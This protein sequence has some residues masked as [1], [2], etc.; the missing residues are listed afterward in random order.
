MLNAGD[1]SLTFFSTADISGL[2][3]TDAGAD[4]DAL[5]FDGLVADIDPSLFVNFETV[6]VTNGAFIT[7]AP[8]GASLLSGPDGIFVLNGS[9]LQLG[10]LDDLLGSLTIDAT[11]TVIAIGD[12]PGL[13]TI[14]GDLTLAGLLDLT[15]G[16]PDDQT[17]V[18][19]D[20]IGQ[21]G[22]IALDVLFGPGGVSE[23][24]LVTFGDTGSGDVQVF[25]DVD[26]SGPVTIAPVPVLIFPSSPGVDLTLAS[27]GVAFDGLFYGLVDF[28]G[29]IFL[30]PDGTY[31]EEV[32]GA[33]AVSAALAPLDRDLFGDLGARIGTGDALRRPGMADG[34][35]GLWA[36]G[37]GSYHNGEVGGGGSNVDFDATHFF[38]Q[39]GVDAFRVDVGDGA[40]VGSVMAHFGRANGDVQ[41]SGAGPDTDFDVTSYGVGVGAT[42]YVGDGDTYFDVAGMVNWHD[43]D[44]AGQD[45]DSMSYVI[46]F[47]A[48]TRIPASDTLSIAPMAQVVYS[49]ADEIDGVTMSGPVLGSG[50]VRVDDLESLEAR[51]LVMLELG[52]GEA[53]SVQFGGGIAYEFMGES[54]TSFGSTEVDTD[55]GGVS[56]EVA[57]R[58]QFRVSETV[59]AFGDLRGR[60]AFGSDGTDSIGGLIGIKIDF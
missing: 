19:G 12:S 11:S 25:L 45:A 60:K 41:Q 54:T 28:S 56:G 29:E 46:G 47:E 31:V 26:M 23:T 4:A 3:V 13:N 42:W 55:F 10:D 8:A 20:L 51:A 39:L 33:L 16:D 38:T 2:G 48:G 49:R 50:Q 22:T 18:T 37:G 53:S 24:D 57:A 6:T 44:I 34:G 15:D 14:T 36:R 1:D 17:N 40:M 43:L 32:A 9:T 5:S 21:G 27:G 30:A 59:T 52:L 58:G 35:G 7:D